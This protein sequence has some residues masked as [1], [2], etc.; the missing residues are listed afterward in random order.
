MYSYQMLRM[1]FVRWMY[2][3]AWNLN[4]FDGHWPTSSVHCIQSNYKSSCFINT[5]MSRLSFDL[6]HHLALRTRDFW[7]Q[8]LESRRL[9]RM[10]L[11]AINATS[12]CISCHTLDARFSLSMLDAHEPHHWTAQFVWIVEHLLTSL[13]GFS[14]DEISTLMS[15]GHP[16]AIRLRQLFHCCR[17][18]AHRSLPCAPMHPNLCLLPPLP[19][20]RNAYN[21]R[22]LFNW[23]SFDGRSRPKR[24]T[25]SRL[26]Q[27]HGVISSA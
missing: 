9:C 3:P 8:M 19:P 27:F 13:D 23:C 11:S 4:L 16:R 22:L 12:L 17:K 20:G 14:F 6:A 5:N 21:F 18:Q 1:L 25:R 15:Q 26:L 24:L 10:I 7:R 2:V